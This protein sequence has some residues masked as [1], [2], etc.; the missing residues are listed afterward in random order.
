MEITITL[1]ADHSATT[2]QELLEREWLVP[3]KV[4]HFLRTRRNVWVNAQPAPFSFRN[5]RWRHN[6]F[7]F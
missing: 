6:Y 4:R 2:I 1:P 5:P 3:K 7:A